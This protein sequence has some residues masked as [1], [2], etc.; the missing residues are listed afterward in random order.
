MKGKQTR[1]NKTKKAKTTAKARQPPEPPERTTNADP[2]RKNFNQKI[3]KNSFQKDYINEQRG[4]HP[5]K[6]FMLEFERFMKNMDNYFDLSGMIE[7]KK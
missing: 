6:N 3:F 7:F 5:L 2:D 4:R 1:T